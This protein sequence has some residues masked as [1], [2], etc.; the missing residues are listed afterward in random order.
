STQE[1]RQRRDT[2]YR[3]MNRLRLELVQ[4][5]ETTQKK[6]GVS[7]DQEYQLPQIQ[8]QIP[9]NAALLTWLEIRTSAT[10]TDANRDYWACLIRA[11]GPPVWVRLDGGGP[12]SAWTFADDAL[13]GDLRKQLQK[14]SQNNAWRDPAHRLAA[15]RLAPLGDHLRSEGYLPA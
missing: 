1:Q 5:Q 2:M 12:V 11:T 14:Q 15:Q 7:A 8:Q 13:P 10:E 4:F 3:E 9:A 6:Y